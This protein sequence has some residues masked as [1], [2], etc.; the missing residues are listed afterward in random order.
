MRGELKEL[1][2]YLAFLIRECDRH[3]S[4]KEVTEDEIQQFSLALSNFQRNC[5]NAQLTDYLM[6][7]VNDLCKLSSYSDHSKVEWV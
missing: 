3:L 1:I 5:D 7:K 6:Q 2:D 4:D